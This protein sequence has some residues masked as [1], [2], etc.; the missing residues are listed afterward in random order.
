MRHETAN[1]NPPFQ[2]KGEIMKRKEFIKN[3]ALFA[4]ASAVLPKFAFSAPAKKG[5]DK[6][7]VGIVGLGGRGKDTLRNMYNADQNIEI[8][9]VGELFP[10]RVENAKKYANE[11]LSKEFKDFK[12]D[13][14][15]KATPETTFYGLDSLDKVLQTDCDVVAL[16]TPPVFRPT[17]IEKCLKAGKH[18][19]AEKP[20]C[21]DPTGYRKIVNELVPLAKEKRLSVLCGTQMRFHSSI[22]EAMERI[23]DGQIGDI[24]SSTC[25]R[26]ENKYLQGWY[27]IPKNLVPEDVEFQMRN[28]L[29]FDWTSG[30]QYVEQYVHNLDLALWGMDALPT[31]VVASG[32]RNGNLKFPQ[33]GNRFTSIAANFEFA[34]GRGLS[35]AARQ[36]DGSAGFSQLRFH[37]SKGYADIT[38]GIQKIFGSKPWT[39]EKSKVPA[40]VAQ[41]IAFLG[42]IRNGEHLDTMERCANSCYIGICGRESAYSGRR[43]K[44]EW[45]AK[46][47]TLNYMP[48]SLELGQKKA[49]NPVPIPGEY[50]LS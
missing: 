37:G 4:G 36:E 7:K 5:S 1:T 6:I 14:F 9:A 19:F 29:A 46:R 27:D 42:A 50:K 15:Y 48:S 47:S 20:I 23:K 11:K 17:Q 35:A 38:F 41:H 8:V 33:N 43:L 45:I 30:D 28:W 16:V 34:D 22:Q 12:F 39:S 32:G 49:I 44:T 3:A 2:K 13:S 40:L 10:E 18:V 24:V 26:Y 21:I 25:I 31:E